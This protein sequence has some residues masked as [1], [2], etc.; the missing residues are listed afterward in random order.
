MFAKLLGRRVDLRLCAGALHEDQLSA[1]P[2]QGSGEGEQLAERTDRP[3][4]HLVEG[5][6]EANLLSARS[7]DG[8]V[9]EPEDADLIVEPGDPTFHRFDEHELDVR[10]SDR[11][12]QSR[13][14]S[15]SADVA[16]SAGTKERRH[17]RAVEDVPR[18]ETRKLQRPDQAEWLTELRKVRGKGT[19][20]IDPVAEQF[21]C[22][23]RFRLESCRHVSHRSF[24]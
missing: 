24:T 16:D 4:S 14:P 17:D 7:H 21:G 10:P 20:D 13:Q 5:L 23:R 6:I 9:L 2:K 8:D 22:F 11:K 18:P 1:V 3:R 19:T 15:S 12:D